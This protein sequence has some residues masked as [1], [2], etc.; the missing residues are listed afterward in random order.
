[1]HV[2]VHERARAHELVIG[3]FVSRFAADVL[4]KQKLEAEARRAHARHVRQNRTPRRNSARNPL[5]DEEKEA[6]AEKDVRALG[7]AKV[8][9]FPRQRLYGSRSSELLKI[10]DSVGAM[11]R[12]SKCKGSGDA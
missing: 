11:V 6:L 4:E 12:G 8:T 9:R 3:C 10:R 5:T 1:V 7:R 2:R